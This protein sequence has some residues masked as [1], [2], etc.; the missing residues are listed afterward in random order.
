MNRAER[1]ATPVCFTYQLEHVICVR[2]EYRHI[3]LICLVR[4]IDTQSSKPLF[5]L[6]DWGAVKFR[7][8]YGTRELTTKK[9]LS[10]TDDISWIC[11]SE[12]HAK[13]MKFSSF[14]LFWFEKFTTFLKGD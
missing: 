4:V 8:G 14:L 3:D 13:A 10:E 12:Q 9:R 1:N 11:Q 6:A 2:H 7:R 5:D